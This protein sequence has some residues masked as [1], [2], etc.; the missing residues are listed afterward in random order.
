MSLTWRIA[1]RDR[2]VAGRGWLSA[3]ADALVVIVV[4]VT[5]Q[6]EVWTPG[7]PLANIVGAALGQLGRLS[8][9]RSRAVV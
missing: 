3:H 9:V 7:W 1:S 5:G 6:Q 2:L 8:A 4:A